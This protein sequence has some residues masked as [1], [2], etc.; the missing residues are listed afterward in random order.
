[1]FWRIM[2]LFFFLTRA[3]IATSYQ[4]PAARL[5]KSYLAAR[6]ITGGWKLAAGSLHSIHR[7]LTIA[8]L[9]LSCMKTAAVLLFSLISSGLFAQNAY[10]IKV[11]LKPFKNQYV[12]L[13]HYYGK[14][15]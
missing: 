6:F 1:M 9:F 13:G 14:Q 10:E 11:T 12:Y 4:L 7:T 3:K 2:F 8:A 15:L 5:V